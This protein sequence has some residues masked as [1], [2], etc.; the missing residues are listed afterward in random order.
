MRWRE[1]FLEDG[2]LVFD[3]EDMRALDKLRHRCENSLGTNDLSSLHKS[4]HINEVNE[5]RL[6]TFNALNSIEDWERLYKSLASSYID[7]LIGPDIAIQSKMN[8]SIQMP[9]DETSLLQLHT[10]ALSGQSIF[11]LVLWVPLTDCEG[12]NSMYLFDKKNSDYMLAQL[13]SYERKGMLAMYRDYED[14]G[15]FIKMTY[16]QCL[17]FTPTL[18]HGNDTNLT[19]WTRVSINCRFKN[20]FSPEANTGERRLG[21]FYR[22]LQM[23]EL[24]RLGLGYRDEMVMF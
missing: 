7:R 18:F 13:S 23:S 17:L 2:Y 6:Q 16:G 4:V 8:L 24:T 12:S 11:E 1:R 15:H 9:H 19:D 10:D 22:V 21:S 14:K 5:K 3:C 20:L